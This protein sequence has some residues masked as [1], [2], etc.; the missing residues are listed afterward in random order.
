MYTEIILMYTNNTGKIGK[1]MWN[2]LLGTVF[3]I[4]SK[5]CLMHNN[6]TSLTYIW[7]L[8]L[9]L[10]DHACDIEGKTYMALRTQFSLATCKQATT[11]ILS[12]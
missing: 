10:S 8:L 2:K 4:L 1:S 12:F 3:K 6:Y 7:Y 5:Q 11:Q 9:L